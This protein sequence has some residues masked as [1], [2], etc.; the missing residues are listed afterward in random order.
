MIGAPK[1]PTG[2]AGTGAAA[3]TFCYTNHD[4]TEPND[5]ASLG[6][7]C[8]LHVQ[9]MSDAPW[10]ARALSGL[11]FPGRAMGQMVDKLIW[12]GDLQGCFEADPQQA[13]QLFADWN[14]EVKRVSVA[15]M[16]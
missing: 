16:L 9:A 15:T 7:S 6:G 2:L 13:Q 8:M 10:Y 11:F 4:I 1:H 5:K 3:A 12:Q 14:E